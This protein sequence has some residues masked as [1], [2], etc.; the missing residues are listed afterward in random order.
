MRNVQ[1]AEKEKAYPEY[2][3]FGKLMPA[4]GVY[5]RHARGISSEHVKIVY[6]AP[7]CAAGR[8]FD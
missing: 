8:G 6:D 2:N 5:I 3:M 1:L 4:Y 7:G